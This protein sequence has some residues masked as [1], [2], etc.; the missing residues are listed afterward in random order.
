MTIIALAGR[1]IDARGEDPAR[2]PLERVD[3]VQGEVRMLLRNLDP[4]ALVCSA[5]CGADLLAL[6][7]AAS[8]MIPVTI[9]LPFPLDQFRAVSVG[10]HPGDWGPR[11]DQVMRNASAAASANRLQVLDAS[12]D[13]ADDADAIDRACAAATDTI[14]DEAQRLAITPLGDAHTLIAIVVWDGAS[15]GED[16]LTDYFRHG[17]ADRGFHVRDICTLLPGALE[18]EKR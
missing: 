11:F 5:S 13:D 16:D 2:F 17:A 8:L 12:A 18:L 10:D 9:V 4:T 3:R 14:L 6:E 15:R 7:A 1:R